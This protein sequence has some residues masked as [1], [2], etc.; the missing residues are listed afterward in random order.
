VQTGA[1]SGASGV[2]SGKQEPSSDDEC[3][4]DECSND[5]LEEGELAW[6]QAAASGLV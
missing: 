3:S 4:G 2:A 5:E 6:L 1:L